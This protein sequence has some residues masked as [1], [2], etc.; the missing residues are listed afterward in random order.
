TESG[1]LVVRRHR[2][3]GDLAAAGLVD[4][5]QRHLDAVAVGLVEDELALALQRVRRGVELARD[6]RVRDLLHTDDDMHGGIT[7]QPGGQVILARVLSPRRNGQSGAQYRFGVPTN[8]EPDLDV[9]VV[10][11]G[12]AGVAAAITADRHGLH[13]ACVDR[14]TFPRDKTCG[15][16]L[17]AAAPR[18]LG[19]PGGAVPG[20]ASTQPGSAGR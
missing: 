12:P 2:H 16:G 5:L 15:D 20:I 6:R 7:P 1:D 19:D 4:E 8:P 11:A 18:P 14:A 10:G 9:L 13:T 3:E 17:P